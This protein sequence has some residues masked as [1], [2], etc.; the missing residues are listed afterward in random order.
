MQSGNIFWNIECS[1]WNIDVNEETIDY[2]V[3]TFILLG[4]SL[5]FTIDKEVIWYYYDNNYQYFQC[6]S[7]FK[8]TVTYCKRVYFCWVM[9]FCYIFKKSFCSKFIRYFWTVFGFIQCIPK[10][11]KYCVTVYSPNTVGSGIIKNAPLKIRDRKNHRF[12]LTKG[13]WRYARRYLWRPD[14]LL[15][16]CPSTF[17]IELLAFH[18]KC[19]RTVFHCFSVPGSPIHS[20]SLEMSSFSSVV[21]P[22]FQESLKF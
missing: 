10:H 5:H 16:W 13:T 17:G 22:G 20:T 11:T 4:F 21:G 18:K 8:I 3:L 9:R 12:E 14:E 15:V 6:D 19:N 2:F 7:F 1:G